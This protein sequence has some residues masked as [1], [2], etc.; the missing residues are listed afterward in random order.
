MVS[1]IEQT[2]SISKMCSLIKRKLLYSRMLMLQNKDLEIIIFRM[3]IFKL[4]IYFTYR[5]IIKIERKKCKVNSRLVVIVKENYLVHLHKGNKNSL[6][7]KSILHQGNS[8]MMLLHL[9]EEQ[10][11]LELELVLAEEKFK[12]HHQDNN[13][14][15][16]FN[17]RRWHGLH[18]KF[19]LNNKGNL[20]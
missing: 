11:A 3:Y 18:N 16:H 9:E 12:D 14:N 13:Y 2:N 19:H 1:A 20:H 7:N 10:V 15:N 5:I 17:N 8:K 6:Y 4:F